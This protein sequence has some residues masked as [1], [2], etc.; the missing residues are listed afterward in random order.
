VVAIAG[1]RHVELDK[2]EETVQLGRDGASASRLARSRSLRTGA[3]RPH[4]LEEA[5]QAVKNG[6]ERLAKAARAWPRLAQLGQHADGRLLTTRKRGLDSSR[7]L[8]PAQFADWHTDVWHERCFAVDP[9]HT[10]LNASTYPKTH[11]GDTCSLRSPRGR[12]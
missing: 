10:W 11:S 3:N 5:A 4:Q 8:A 9:W 2:F 12:K 7:K 6:D 1:E